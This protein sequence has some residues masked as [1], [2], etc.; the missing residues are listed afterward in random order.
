MVMGAWLVERGV[1]ITV[2]EST[3]TSWKG[4]LHCL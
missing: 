4:L 3:S 1:T 2:I